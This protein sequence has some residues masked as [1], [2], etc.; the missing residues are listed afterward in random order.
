MRVTSSLAAFVVGSISCLPAA[1]AWGAAG[2]AILYSSCGLFIYLF[3]SLQAM[4]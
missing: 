3:Y 4:R 2:L 1:H